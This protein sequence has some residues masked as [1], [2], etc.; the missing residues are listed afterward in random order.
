MLGWSACKMHNN[1]VLNIKLGSFTLLTWG[2]LAGDATNTN[3]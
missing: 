3:R 1:D 2:L